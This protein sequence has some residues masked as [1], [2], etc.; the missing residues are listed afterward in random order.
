MPAAR[1]E[2]AYVPQ[3]RDGGVARE[4]VRDVRKADVRAVALHHERHD[5]VHGDVHREEDGKGVPRGAD[6]AD[7]GPDPHRG[8]ADG[9]GV[10]C[11]AAGVLGAAEQAEGEAG[12]DV[13]WRGAGDGEGLGEGRLVELAG[14]EEVGFRGGDG[15]REEGDQ[16]RVGEVD[17]GE[18][19]ESYGGVALD[20][21]D[22]ELS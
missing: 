21:G 2:Q 8:A 17:R 12:G 22:W 18:D 7:G 11:V 10:V 6:P 9:G 16:G 14:L 13:G 5:P 4:P 3:G 20:A 1:G 15:A 19:G